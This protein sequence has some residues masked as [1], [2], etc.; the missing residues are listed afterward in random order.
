MNSN[1][2]RLAKGKR[3]NYIGDYVRVLDKP[4]RKKN[5]RE[6]AGVG[7][8]GDA[9]SGSSVDLEPDAKDELLC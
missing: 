5:E 3:R 9:I 4:V 1:A 8:F 7:C 2:K 6:D